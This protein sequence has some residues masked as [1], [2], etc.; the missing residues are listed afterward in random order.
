LALEL[1]DD[2]TLGADLDSIAYLDN[3]LEQLL[4][5]FID[6]LRRHIGAC[7]PAVQ[8]ADTPAFEALIT[9]RIF[10][11]LDAFNELCL[12][13][14]C[15][16]RDFLHLFRTSTVAA[17]RR[18]EPKIRV[19][20]IR[21]AARQ[22]FDGK[23]KRFPMGSQ[24]LVFLEHIYQDIV[25]PQ[26]SYVFLLRDID[27]EHPIVGA[28]WGGR[29]LHK[30][31][32]ELSYYQESTHTVFRYYQMDYGKCV[33]LLIAQARRD[34][35]A[36]GEGFSKM[37]AGIASSASGFVERLTVCLTA[38]AAP[39]VTRWVREHDAIASEPGGTLR[40]DPESILV[41]PDAFRRYVS[42]SGSQIKGSQRL[43]RDRGN[44]SGSR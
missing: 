33:E 19:G 35:T 32:L 9:E 43:A 17:F 5:F 30:M 31:P 8:D 6:L 1:G 4:P 24:E 27:T 11:R 3:G 21:Q 18:N 44:R 28:L 29:L 39:L 34:G 14:A 15:V 25:A 36:E 26:H 2:I 13:S 38:I 10:S 37:A 16:P 42:H 41:T 7:L 23:S 12:A 40:A 22:S 20:D